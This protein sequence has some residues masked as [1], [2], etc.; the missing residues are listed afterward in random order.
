MRILLSLDLSTTCTGWSVLDIDQSTLSKIERNERNANEDMI[1]KIAQI[2]D[3]D[4][5]SLKVSFLSDKI[6]YDLMDEALSNEVLRVA[7]EKVEY[8]RNLKK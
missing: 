3:A 8:F 4:F 6:A 7:E 2:F 1:A 5:K